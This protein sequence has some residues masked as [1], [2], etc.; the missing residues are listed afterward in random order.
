MAHYSFSLVLLS[1]I[2]AVVGSLM[3]LIA[4]RDALL[5]PENSRRGLI[6]L[7]ALSLGGVAIWSMHFI[8]MLAFDMH[9]MDMNYNGWL[10]VLSF[11]VGVGVVYIGLMIMVLG[12]FKLPKLILA[13]ILVGLGV[14][15]M[16]YTGMLSMEVQADSHWN[17]S[18]VAVSI[19]IAIAAAIVALWLAVHV[20][21]MWQMVASALVMGVAVCGMHY[22]GMVAV[23]FVHNAALPYVTSMSVT[24]SVFSLT[25]ATLDAVIIILALAQALSES[26]QRKFHPAQ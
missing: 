1:Y 26:N 6:L 10:T 23:D 12:K 25:I 21:H 24:A 11:V 5:R 15:G 16:H 20:K 2:I 9:G 22:T 17:W 14:A 19:G 3:A 8:G 4:T 7:A 18:L 13:G